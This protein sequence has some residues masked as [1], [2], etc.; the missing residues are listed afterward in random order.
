MSNSDE[1]KNLDQEIRNSNAIIYY[2]R[3]ETLRLNY[4]VVNENHR[5]LK[6]KLT[7]FN[8][9]KFLLSAW[10][11]NN[12]K[13]LELI[14]FDIIR[15]LLNYLSSAMSL[16]EY[17]RNLIQ[18]WY[19]ET[20][21]HSDYLEKVKNTF[22]KVP[23]VGF[24]EDL[25]NYSL[26]YSLPITFP[27][28]EARIGKNQEVDE[29]KHNFLMDKDSLLKWNNWKPKSKPFLNT[30]PKEINVEEFIDL[31]HSIITDFHSWLFDKIRKKHKKE[32][33]WLSNKSKELND[34]ISKTF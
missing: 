29:L 4:F 10:D 6:D 25:R 11:V 31:Y 24:V 30:Q 32:L 14:Q 13:S 5:S 15:R 18:E 22:E 2:Y 26:H 19:K 23:V 8:D 17:T 21:I 7:T 9:P 27:Q 33:E 20:E 34:I 28:F 12:R 16:K 1:A 3:L